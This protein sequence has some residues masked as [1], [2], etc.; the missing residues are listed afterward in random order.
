M[1]FIIIDH[2]KHIEPRKAMELA[3][4]VWAV[5]SCIAGFSDA[6]IST[7]AYSQAASIGQRYTHVSGARLGIRERKRWRLDVSPLPSPLGFGAS[8]GGQLCAYTL[9][10]DGTH[11]L[12]HSFVGHSPAAV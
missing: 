10:W 3:F 8:V 12:C 1:D 2:G 11:L 7:V 5:G 9:S 6:F 4:T